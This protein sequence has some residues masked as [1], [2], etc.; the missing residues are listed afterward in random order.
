MPWGFNFN[1]MVRHP[2][3]LYEAGLE[4]VLLFTVVWI[5][6]SKPRPRLSISGLFL[7]IYNLLPPPEARDELEAHRRRLEADIA[8]PH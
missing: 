6:S 2:S 5:F 3:Q 8:P 4:G 7:V 1:G